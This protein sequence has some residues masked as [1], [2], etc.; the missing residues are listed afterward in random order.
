VGEPRP[1]QGSVTCGDDGDHGWLLAR[2]RGEDI[3]HIPM[4]VRAKY[5]QLEQ[6]LAALPDPSAGPR[7]RPR[8]LAAVGRARRRRVWLAAGSVAA[9]LA[10]AVYLPGPP[11]VAPAITVVVHHG[12]E[13]HRGASTSIGDV[14]AVD[15]TTARP[16]ELRVYGDTGE[17]LARCAEAEGCGGRDPS[18]RTVHFELVLRSPGDVRTMMFAGD[19]M[20]VAFDSLEGDLE[21]ARHAGIEVRQISSVHVQ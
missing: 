2:E 6:L 15:V 18:Q 20:P 7:W 8:V 10:L 11:A 17:P 9:A 12:G 14:L 13:P 3:S 19:A 5:E 1:Q 4:H 16:F 21:A